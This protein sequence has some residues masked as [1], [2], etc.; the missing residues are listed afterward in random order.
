MSC[1]RLFNRMPSVYKRKPGSRSYKDYTDEKLEECLEA[2]RTGRLSQR[3]AEA[4]FKISRA[5]I[6][7]K[8]KNRFLKKPGHPTIFT[9]DEE[10]AFA[11]HIVLLSE[12]GFPVDELDF[13]FIVKTYLTSLGRNVTQ[14][15]N[16]LPGKDWVR[17]FL[18]R[19]Q[20]LTVRFA[21]NI[22]KVRAGVNERILT[23][24]IRNL[25]QVVED[26]PPERIY[27]YDESNLCDDPGKKRIICRRGCKYPERILNST[28]SST[29]VMFCGNAAGTTIPPY[30]IYKAEHLWST[31]TENGPQGARYNRTRHGWMD[32]ATFEEWFG[33]HL[34]PILKQQPGKKV[35]I[36][37]NLTSHISLN[38]LRREVCMSTTEFDSHYAATRYSLFQTP[39]N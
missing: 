6:K 21:A 28:K 32:G 24:Y 4:E 25:S 5:T 17:L 31:W 34:L 35:V 39:E 15:K 10:K 8:L 12:F 19:H 27:N 13:R 9:N 30:V 3:K 16:N 36:G 29:S 23:E 20:Q 2:I 26:V 18:K 1:S 33:S 38:V 14:F 37:D 11:S 22:K 7:N